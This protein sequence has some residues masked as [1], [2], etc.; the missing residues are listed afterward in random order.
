MKG[1]F[2]VL[3]IHDSFFKNHKCL[4]IMSNICHQ[5]KMKRNKA[6]SE[7]QGEWV[8]L[9]LGVQYSSN[10]PSLVRPSLPAA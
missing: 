9:D 4:M 7:S 10:L 5:P 6:M 8:G 3:I 2:L 1:T